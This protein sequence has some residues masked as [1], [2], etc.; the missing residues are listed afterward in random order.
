[1]VYKPFRMNCRRFVVACGLVC[2]HYRAG[3]GIQRGNI[4]RAVIVGEDPL[5]AGIVIDPVGTF[6]D[7]YLVNELQRSRVEHRNLVLAAIAG[8]SVLEGGC[9]RGSVDSRC[10]ADRPDDLAAI[11]I[12]NVNLSR[13]RNVKPPRRFIE[14][15][16][17]KPAAA[18]NGITAYYLIVGGA[19]QQQRGGEETSQYYSHDWHRLL[20][21]LQIR[22]WRGASPVRVHLFHCCPATR[23]L[24]VQR[25]IL[26]STAIKAQI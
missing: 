2:A 14:R 6:T 19:L 26:M 9:D 15:D 8:K 13:V 25:A 17:I 16:V 12:Y 4:V 3:R 18:G 5:G 21:W 22:T 10:V 23:R 24:A 1:A 20:L 7:V 11:G